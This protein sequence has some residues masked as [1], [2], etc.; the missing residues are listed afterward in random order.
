MYRWVPT[1]IQAQ[2][3]A[4]RASKPR[5]QEPSMSEILSWPSGQ[6]NSVRCAC[7]VM[8]NVL[9]TTGWCLV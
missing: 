2:V 3:P 6:E 7:R 1:N 4:G 5:T 9:P 8:E